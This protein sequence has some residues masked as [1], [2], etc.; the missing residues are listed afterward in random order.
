MKVPKRNSPRA[1][2]IIPPQLSHRLSNLS[3]KAPLAG[4]LA[5]E[6]TIEQLEAALRVGETRQAQPPK[7]NVEEPA[8]EIARQWLPA[9]DQ[10]T[11]ERPRAG[12]DAR[13]ACQQH[14]ELFDRRREIG[15]GDEYALATARGEASAHSRALAA[16]SG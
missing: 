15:V 11:P 5:G 7:R 12:H 13:G 3:D 1:T 10:L 8:E 4:A 9:R 16:V 6:F 2:S 14:V